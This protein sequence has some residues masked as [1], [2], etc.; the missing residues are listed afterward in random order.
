MNKEVFEDKLPRD[1]LSTLASHMR[2]VVYSCVY[3][4]VMREPD[5]G[6]KI[7]FHCPG[8]CGQ[9]SFYQDHYTKAFNV[10]KQTC[11]CCWIPLFTGEEGG[12]D[13]PETWC[14][15]EEKKA[16][17]GYADWF[18][19]VP[20][21]V[22]KCPDLQQV[23]LGYMGVNPEPLGAL[24]DWVWWLELPAIDD[25]HRIT[26][27]VAILYSYLELQASKKIVKPAKGF[28]LCSEC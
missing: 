3:H 2:D 22:W 16:N 10:N 14:E 18:W 12:F 15:G 23:V 8:P 13:H 19:C 1:I 20:Y 4:S 5:N 26:H 6:H 27:A 24:I 9:Q 28:Q 7:L 11:A 17:E 21:L 25:D